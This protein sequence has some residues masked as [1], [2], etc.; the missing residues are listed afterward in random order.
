MIPRRSQLSNDSFARDHGE[1]S[2]TMILRRGLQSNDSLAHPSALLRIMV[3]EA[4]SL[5]KGGPKS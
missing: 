4:L 1:R 2:R 3:S 5:P